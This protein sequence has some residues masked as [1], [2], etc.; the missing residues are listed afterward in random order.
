MIVT[1][2]GADGVV[3][4]SAIAHWMTR[5]RVRPKVLSRPQ[6]PSLSRFISCPLLNLLHAK[7][8]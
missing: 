5:V 7:K 3:T 2:V 6:P 1:H 4:Y 8:Q